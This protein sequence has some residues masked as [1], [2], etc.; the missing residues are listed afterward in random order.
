MSRKLPLNR[1]IAHIVGVNP[2]ELKSS[3][4]WRGDVVVVAFKS[5]GPYIDCHNA[6]TSVTGAVE[7]MLRH[8]YMEG[9]LERVLDIDEEKCK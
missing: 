3:M 7:V 8:A 1:C 4:F 5:H 2:D 9:R 6:D